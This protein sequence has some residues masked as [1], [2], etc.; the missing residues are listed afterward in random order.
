LANEGL[1]SDVAVGE[2][3]YGDVEGQSWRGDRSIAG[4]RRHFSEG[5]RGM[6]RDMKKK[7]KSKGRHDLWNPYWRK[8]EGDKRKSESKSRLVREE[9]KKGQA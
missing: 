8:D 2:G 6:S 4:G 7:K 5:I 1:V 9:R 3:V